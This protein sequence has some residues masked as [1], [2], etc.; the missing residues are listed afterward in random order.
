MFNVNLICK[1][2]TE[3]FTFYSIEKRKHLNGHNRAEIV[4]QK[5]QRKREKASQRTDGKR[6]LRLRRKGKKFFCVCLQFSL[7]KNIPQILH[8]QE[9]ILYLM[10]DYFSG[11]ILFAPK[12]FLFFYFCKWQAPK[13]AQKCVYSPVKRKM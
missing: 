13:A 9:N 12:Y 2:G 4:C 8:K 6:N 5:Q 7:L 3:L 1:I 10:S 11:V